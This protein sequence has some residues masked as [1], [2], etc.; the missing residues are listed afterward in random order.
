MGLNTADGHTVKLE[1]LYIGFPGLLPVNQHA[2]YGP[3]NLDIGHAEM[4]GII[5]RNGIGK[6]TL[7]RTITGL[8]DQIDGKVFFDGIEN[9]RIAQKDLAKLVSFV[10]TESINIQHLRVIDLVALGRFPYT[11]WLGKLTQVDHT[12]VHE[13]IDRTGLKLFAHKPVHHLSD[14]E[15]QKVMIARALAQDTPVI[16]L[17]EPTAFLDLPSRHEILRLLND[18]SRH[19]KKTIIF[20]THDLAIAMDEADR[21]CLMTDQGFFDGAPEDLLINQVFRKLFLNSP[22]E[23]D[24]KTYAFR[25]KRELTRTVTIHGEKK[26]CSI[27]RKAMERI[28]FLTVEEDVADA[29][30]SIKFINEQLCW[31]LTCKETNTSFNSVYALTSFLKKL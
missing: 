28:G 27:T 19:N 12:I 31:Q 25:F 17:D 13:A 18:L 23:F 26:Y 22:V 11:G 21:L 29:E 4:V 30:I 15:R 16:I 8:Q 7:L 14:G 24:S 10:S 20:S 5:G 1:N 6:S 3:V 2:I 9:S